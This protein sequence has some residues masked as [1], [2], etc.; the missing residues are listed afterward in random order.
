MH[1]LSSILG[2]LVR[3]RN[4]SS[5]YIDSMKSI[6]ALHDETINVWS[7]LVATIVFSTNTIWCTPTYNTLRSITRLRVD[8]VAKK[9]FTIFIFQTAATLCF[10]C[11]TLYHIFAN[12]PQARWWQRLDHFGIV[13]LFWASTILFILFFFDYKQYLQQVY[14]ALVTASAILSLACLRGSPLHRPESQ[15]DRIATHIVFGGIATLP[16]AHC[17]TFSTH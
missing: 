10:A 12:H 16:A 11:S 3:R 8:C 1:V 15:W 7:H 5:S 14:T 9:A 2:A 17:S 4:R 13:A 6:I